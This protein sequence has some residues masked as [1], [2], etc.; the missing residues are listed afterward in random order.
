MIFG[1]IATVAYAEVV[2]PDAFQKVVLQVISLTEQQRINFVNNVLDQIT[3][4][5]YEDYVD[6]AKAILG[7]SMS[8]SDMEKALKSYAYYP[9]TL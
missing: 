8:D 7:L 9:D 1:V 4:E 6:D 2:Q 5:N 3:T